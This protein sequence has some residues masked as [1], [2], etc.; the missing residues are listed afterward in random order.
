MRRATYTRLAHQA[1]FAV[2]LQRRGKHGAC[3]ILFFSPGLAFIQGRGCLYAGMVVLP[4]YSLQ[5][6][7][8]RSQLESLLNCVAELVLTL[9]KMLPAMAIV[10]GEEKGVELIG[11]GHTLLVHEIIITHPEE[12]A[13][14][15]EGH[16]K[17]IWGGGHRCGRLPE[18]A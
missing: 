2:G 18:S 5:S 13:P 1:G 14:Y 6:E 4:L 16:V 17:E 12:R 9:E 11:C 7:E 8:K 10:A 3:V 15:A